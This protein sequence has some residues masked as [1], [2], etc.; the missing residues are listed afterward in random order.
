MA[1]ARI[2]YLPPEHREEFRRELI[3]AV[4]GAEPLA[5]ATSVAQVVAE[6]RHTAEVYADPELLSILTSE[7]DD[8]GPVPAPDAP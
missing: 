1:F 8:F 7:G 3:D 4:K 6:W 2:Q 5:D